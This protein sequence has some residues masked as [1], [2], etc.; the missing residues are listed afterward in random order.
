MDHSKGASKL[1]NFLYQSW[2]SGHCHAWHD[3]RSCI[4][5]AAAAAAGVQ[6]RFT[7]IFTSTVHFHLF[8]F[9]ITLSSHLLPLVAGT[10]WLDWSG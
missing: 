7:L 8:W 1:Q 3:C 9:R 6:L 10:Y 2:S 5:L 4:L